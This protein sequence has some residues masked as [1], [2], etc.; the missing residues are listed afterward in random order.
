[1]NIW[2][3]LP[4]PL[5]ANELLTRAERE[6]VTYVPGKHFAVTR[7]DPCGLRLSFGSL[8]PG[9]IRT[10]IEILGRI[11]KEEFERGKAS[12]RFEAA[13]ALV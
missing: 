10:G 12:S 4:A 9:P 11:F 7:E 5:D 8:S 2:V 3:R 13:S 1:M 6:H